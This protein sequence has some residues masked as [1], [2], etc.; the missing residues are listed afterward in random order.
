MKR[1][2]ETTK[3]QKRWAV[4]KSSLCAVALA[5]GGSAFMASASA[6]ASCHPDGQPIS[7]EVIFFSSGGSYGNA[8]Q[9]HYFEPFEKECG[10]KVVHS[11]GSRN[12]SQLQQFVDAGNMP[13][14]IGATISDQ[15]YP[16]GVREGIFHKLPDGFWD[17][18]ASEMVEGS[19]S[20]YGA[21]ASPYSDVL[22]YSTAGGAPAMA[23]W[24]DFWD[25]ER[26]PGPRMLQN[27]PMSLVIALLA[28][29]VEPDKIYPLDVDRAFAKLDEIRPEIRAFWTSADQPVQGVATGE[30]VAG[31]TWNG[32][33]VTAM[34][35]DKPVAISWDGALLHSSWTFI[36]KGAKNARNA[37]A[38]LYY[39][40]RAERQAALA[41]AI[42]YSGGNKNVA[43]MV[44]KAVLDI[45]P[46]APDHVAQAS[47]ID[48][49]W[50]ADNIADVQK[51]W[52][53]WV[54]KQ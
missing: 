39:M 54:V 29:G 6:A 34:K 38:L 3:H 22:V 15:E 18:I 42:G 11:T 43:E 17:D 16:L 49:A 27:G 7:G 32:R 20:E 21:W 44:D 53:A 14:D 51:R 33:A 25:T 1:A 12:F 26:F 45:L 8:I 47:V 5:L 9:E 36:L 48:G 2:N 37:E 23:T 40:Q 10:V 41:N 13:W 4:P 31:S 50:W 35:S 52:D 30:F 24:A 19:T 46:T 28:D